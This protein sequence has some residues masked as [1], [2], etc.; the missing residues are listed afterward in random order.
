MKSQRLIVITGLSGSGKT[1]AARVLE[2]EG[3]YVVDNLPPDQLPQFLKL[4]VW[5]EEE[6]PKVAVVMDVR[7]RKFMATEWPK[8]IDRTRASGY[9]VEIWFFDAADDDLIRRFSETRRRHPLA[10]ME[11]VP[12]AVK[13]EREL[14]ADIRSLATAVFDSTGLSIHQLRQA[15]LRHLHSGEETGQPLAVSLQSF[16]YRFG[17]PLEADLVIDVRF[18]P[19]PHYDQTLRPLTGLDP[20]VRNF[21][22]SQKSCQEFLG[23]FKKMLCFLLP[24]YQKEGKRY[25]TIAVGCTGGRHRSVAIVE[26]LRSLFAEPG[27]TL[28]VQHRDLAK[29]QAS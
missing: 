4:T 3:F 5:K 23:Y 20:A 28:N 19:N 18:L 27:Y 6:G 22:L 10:Q 25:L 11:G 17:L 21:V 24:Q 26:D 9:D 1:T 2:D 7:S 15:I 29:G 12:E 16:G 14:L 8:I 13:R